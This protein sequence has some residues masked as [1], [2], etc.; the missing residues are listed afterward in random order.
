MAPTILLQ[1]SF[2]ADGSGAHRPEYESPFIS[3]PRTMTESPA[4]RETSRSASVR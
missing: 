3:Q 1:Y 4:C 2:H